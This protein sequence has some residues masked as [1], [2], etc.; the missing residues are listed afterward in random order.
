MTKMI[1]KFINY[2]HNLQANSFFY[3][4]FKLENKIITLIKNN[5]ELFL[6]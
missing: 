3:L 5:N 2:N 6:F 4:I 1:I